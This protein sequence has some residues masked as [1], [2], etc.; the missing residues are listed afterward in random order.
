V[1]SESKA[2]ILI[3]NDLP[4]QLMALQAILANLQEKIMI[5]QSGKEAL[6]HLAA[7]RFAV[8]LLDVMMPEMDGFETATLI[9]Q[10]EQ[11]WHTPIIF[12]TGYAPSDANLVRSY[13]LGAVD[14]IQTPIVPEI[15]RAKVSVFVE[16]FKKTER[17][18]QQA[19]ELRKRINE[20][21]EI[22]QEL[23]VFSYSL[24]HDLRAPLRAI[25]NFTSMVLNTC[26]ER[27][28]ADGGNHQRTT[29]FAAAQSRNQHRTSC[30]SDARG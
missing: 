17:I 26:G 13:S 22:N 16:L 18:E 1:R 25:H 6:N 12:V 23:E 21:T 28:G 10:Q 9:R 24:S 2:N 15:L 14:Y 30:A 7:N 27:L 19:A 4:E 3:V 29:W 20:L 8:I 5:A 11:S